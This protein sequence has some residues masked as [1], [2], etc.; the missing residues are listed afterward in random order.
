V[1]GQN[2]CQ[3]DFY[4]VLSDKVVLVEVKL[5]G[6]PHGKMQAEGL[7]KPLLEKIYGRP[8][9]CLLMCKW[10]GQDTPGP[11]V[12]SPEEFLASE[13]GFATMQWLGE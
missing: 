9:V 4:W 7:Y 5:T 6:G 10:V 8:V 11:F 3:T 13:V 2:H 12:S 1:L